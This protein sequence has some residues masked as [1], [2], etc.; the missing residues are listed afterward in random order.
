MVV[1]LA[2][3]SSCIIGLHNWYLNKILSTIQIWCKDLCS[4]GN[5]IS[6]Y[7]CSMARGWWYLPH[8]HSTV[9]VPNIWCQPGTKD[10]P[11]TD[12][13]HQLLQT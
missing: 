5:S 6:C 2:D 1:L 7:N 3:D 9:F 4:W 8:G 11:L 12:K 10:T 13:L